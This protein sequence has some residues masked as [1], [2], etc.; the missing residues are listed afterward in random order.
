VTPAAQLANYVV[1]K[2]VK[3][4]PLDLMALCH[5]LGLRIREVPAKGFDGALIRSKAG[6][7]GIVAVKASIREASRKRFTIAHEIG[8]FIIPHHRNLENICEERK[9]ESFDRNLNR[10]EME[11]N[12]FAA[13]L[14]LPSGALRK[15]FN[16][17]QFSLAQISAVAAEYGTSLTATTRSFLTL[18]DL[19]CAM[20]WSVA[21]RARWFVRSDA[22]RFFL[23]LP[24]F[25]RTAPSPPRFSEANQRPQNLR[26]SDRMPGSTVR[27]QK[28]SIH[29]SST[30]SVFPTT[31]LCSP[32]FGLT[33]WRR[34]PPGTTK[35]SCSTISTQRISR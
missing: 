2:F 14:L 32:C 31:T 25:R 8:H 19:S 23:R 33:R 29:Y 26:P 6:Q 15:L 12:E 4:E 18:T 9:I 7:K 34:C 35:R 3:A 5:E 16:L 30:P 10:P 24:N 22:F 11:A 13:E 20:I 27:Q 1:A 17:A 28:T 21:N